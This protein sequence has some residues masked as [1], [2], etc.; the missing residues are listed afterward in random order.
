PCCKD[1]FYMSSSDKPLAL[2]T[3][4][5]RRVGRSIAERFAR[6]GYAVAIHYGSSEREAQ[7]LQN[8]LTR[9][10]HTAVSMQADLA[11]GQAIIRMIDTVYEKFGRLDVLVNCAAVFFPDHL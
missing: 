5:A 9:S 11:D 1:S 2:I 3:G 10:G 4:A 6:E 8:E 7:Q